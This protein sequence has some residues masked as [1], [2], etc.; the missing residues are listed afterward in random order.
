VYSVSL[1]NIQDAFVTDPASLILAGT[2]SA[3]FGDYITEQMEK[4]FACLIDRDA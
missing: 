3:V 4:L 2:V 1:S